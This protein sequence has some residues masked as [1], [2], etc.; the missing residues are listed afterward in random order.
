MEP[1][2][3]F[4][5]EYRWL[6][7]FHKSEITY[8][9][10]VY[11]S[12]EA[13]YQAQKTLDESIRDEFI[14]LTPKEAKDRGQ[15]V[16]SREDWNKVKV[17]FMYEVLVEK[18]KDRVLRKKLLAT[19]D[20]ELIEGNTWHDNTWGDC[21]CYNCK[22]IFGKNFLGKNLMLVRDQIKEGLV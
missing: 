20:A 16:K 21:T 14:L 18:F 9:G 13:A 1:I 7:N 15:E 5:G 11:G 10:R 2:E 17:T 6:S 8:R 19:G 4:W 3:K 22:D 12:T